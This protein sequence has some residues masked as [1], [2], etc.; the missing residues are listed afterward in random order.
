MILKWMFILVFLSCFKGTLSTSSKNS[1]NTSS[2]ILQTNFFPNRVR[3]YYWCSNPNTPDDNLNENPKVLIGMFESGIVFKS[4]DGGQNFT[5]LGIN[6]SVSTIHQHPSFPNLLYFFSF[7]RTL[8]YLSDDCGYT[9][10]SV[11]DLQFPLETMI[12]N[13]EDPLFLL[14]KCLET[15]YFFSED[16]GQRWY[17]IEKVN[18]SSI[19]NIQWAYNQK[20]LLKTA[21]AQR[22]VAQI[23]DDV[24]YTDDFFFTTHSIKRN[25]TNFTLQS[26]FLLM[27]LNDDNGMKIYLTDI[28]NFNDPITSVHRAHIPKFVDNLKYFSSLE[29]DGIFYLLVG[30]KETNLTLLTAPLQ[31]DYKF[32]IASKN[33]LSPKQCYIVKTLTGIIIVNQ[34]M[35]PLIITTIISFN[36]GT[37]WKNLKLNNSTESLNLDLQTIYSS[38]ST[39]GL[40][41]SNGNI[42]DRL[43]PSDS[44]TYL[45]RNGGYSWYEI[46]KGKHIFAVSDV[47]SLLVLISEDLPTNKFFY[48]WNQG[49]SFEIYTFSK[50]LVKTLNISMEPNVFSQKLIIFAQDV[51]TM[52]GVVFSVKFFQGICQGIWDPNSAESDYETWLPESEFSSCLLGKKMSIV[53]RKRKATCFNPEL[54]RPI[55]DSYCECDENDYQCDFGFVFNVSKNTCDKERIPEDFNTECMNGYITILTGYRKIPGDDCN[56][57]IEKGYYQIKCQEKKEN[58]NTPI[59][60]SDWKD[61]LMKNYFIIMVCV[62][63]VLL[64]CF[65]KV[66]EEYFSERLTS[67]KSLLDFKLTQKQE[68]KF[69]KRLREDKHT[70]ERISEVNEDQETS[71]LIS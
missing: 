23:N 32:I 54:D 50:N 56:G 55:I 6:S 10:I 2:I 36:K 29:L 11:K 14:V 24:L 35:D 26:N 71:S 13:Y 59:K 37:T 49:S 22:I 31:S 20:N 8:I 17:S 5:E 57:G 42:G 52:Q 44:N 65:H 43:N 39:I 61:Y 62:M 63:S 34:M 1:S 51:N 67:F 27:N 60:K 7:S 9:V 70:F 64:C 33:I 4:D 68:K 38:H 53:R 40:L 28:L 19:K 25:V 45:S 18:S 3:E 16:S 12:F 21:K 48:S 41:L 69:L 30:S 66:I 46:K 58:T 15:G 47:G